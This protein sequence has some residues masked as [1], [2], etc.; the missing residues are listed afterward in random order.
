MVNS[1]EIVTDR[2][3]VMTVYKGKGLEFDNVVVLNAVDDIYPFYMVNKVLRDPGS[4]KEKVARA[5]QSRKEDARKFYVAISRAKK[6]L[7][8]SY[9]TR[10]SW[11]Y[12]RELTP[13]MNSIKHFFYTG[14]QS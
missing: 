5:K 10:N 7:C 14:R 11:G 9:H 13:F 2:I 6:R 12:G 4:S 1:S 8:V 3:F